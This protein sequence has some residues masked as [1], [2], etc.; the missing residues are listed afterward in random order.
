MKDKN[1]KIKVKCPHCKHIMQTRSKLVLITCSSC[2]R[3]IAKLENIDKR[4]LDG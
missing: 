4:R 1:N 2:A 3:K